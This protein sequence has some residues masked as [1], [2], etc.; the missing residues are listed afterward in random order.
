MENRDN[1]KAYLAQIYQESKFFS[2][3]LNSLHRASTEI[4][5]Y[6]TTNSTQSFSLQQLAMSYEIYDVDEILEYLSLFEIYYDQ[7]T[8]KWSH[9]KLP[10]NYERTLNVTKTIK[11][12][13]SKQ[14]I[15]LD[16]KNQ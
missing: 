16:Q 7:D 10:N 1:F 13:L 14:D 6:I 11:I 4:I 3:K 15:R 12:C 2:E 9:N 5:K 8:G